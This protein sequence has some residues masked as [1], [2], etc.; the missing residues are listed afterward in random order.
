MTTFIGQRPAGD[1]PVQDSLASLV[2][3][4]A[5]KYRLAHEVSGENDAPPDMD[6]TLEFFR[7]VWARLGVRYRVAA[8]IGSPPEHAG[9]LNSHVLVL[10]ALA[11]LQEGE[12]V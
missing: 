1:I 2:D 7:D 11:A 3:A 6:S 12:P 4:L 5:G 8:A 9:P 10:R